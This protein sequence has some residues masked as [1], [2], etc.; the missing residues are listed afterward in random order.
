MSGVEEKIIPPWCESGN[1]RCQ[2]DQS[3]DA[4]GTSERYPGGATR[5]CNMSLTT[6]LYLCAWNFVFSLF[7]KTINSILSTM[8]H[9]VYAKRS[10]LSLLAKCFT[11]TS[12][13]FEKSPKVIWSKLCVGTAVEVCTDLCCYSRVMPQPEA[14]ANYCVI[15][16]IYF[17]FK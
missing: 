3:S 2:P 5:A 13:K 11:M 17:T 8:F 14:R 12:V 6:A 7:K 9:S 16:C 15:H 4:C 10:I 1:K